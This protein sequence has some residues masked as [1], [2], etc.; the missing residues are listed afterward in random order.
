MNRLLAK[1]VVLC[2]GLAISSILYTA[3]LDL[4]QSPL[5]VSNSVAPMTMIVLT[6]D[7]KLY[8]EAYNDA[9]DVDGDGELDIGFNPNIDYFGYF[10][11]YK[12]YNYSSGD[13]YFY[14]VSVT[15][16][17]QCA[18]NWSGNFLNYVTTARLDALRKVLYGGYRSTDTRDLTILER[19]Y[20]PQD[21]HSWGK[22]YNSV[23][24]NGYNISNYTPFSKPSSNRYHLFANTTLKNDESAGPLLRVALDQPYRI[25]EWVS[26]ERPVA[27][28]RARNGRNGPRIY[29][30]TD[31]AVRVKV[32]DS[33]VGLEANCSVYPNGRYKPTGLLQ[34]F[35][36][37]DSM[38]FGLMTGS[39]TNNIQGGVLRKQIG[40]IQNEINLNNG[41]F[42]KVN[43]II[44][45][46]N[47]LNI[48]NFD[49]D[50]E[51]NP[52]CGFNAGA[53]V[54]GQCA[55]WG[56]P[57]A[58]IMYEAT[59]YFAGKNTPTSNFTY[60]S[61]LDDTLGL[62]KP[63][64]NNPY[65]DFPVCSKANLLVI[66]DIYPDYDSD[67]I[68][69]SYFQSTS[70]DLA[71]FNAQAL[72]QTIFS[73]EGLS[74]LQVFIGQSGADD[75]AAPTPK[76]VT[77]FG[78]IRGL[79]PHEPSSEGSYYAA[80]VSYFGLI[81]DV[82]GAEGKQN[83]RTYIVGLS[84]NLPEFKFRVGDRTIQ[85]IPYAKTVGHRD[86]TVYSYKPT[87]AI[88]DYYIET[89]TPNYALFRINFEIQQQG[90]DFDMDAIVIYEV[91]V[92]PNNT[93]TV[94]LISDEAAGERIQHLGY[95]I[96]GTTQDGMYLEV[97]DSATISSDDQ[98]YI[99]DTP[100]GKLPGGNGIDGK[101]LPLTASRTFTPSSTSAAVF[102]QS[103]LWY[104]A[105]W[106]GF[107]DE[108]DNNIPDLSTEWDSDGDGNPDNYFLVN[109]S[110]NLNTQLT[111]LFQKIIDE[112]TS[113]ASV[114]VS[115]GFLGSETKIFQ[116]IF[117]PQGW[118]G[119]L[120]A[121]DIDQNNGNVLRN[122]GA[123]LGARW[124][125][126]IVLKN[127]NYDSGRK[128]I[129][130]NYSSGKGVPFRWPGNPANPGNSEI[131]LA[132]VT[133]L[134]TNPSTGVVDNRGADRLNYLRGNQALEQKNGG[135]FRDR[136]LLLGDI[137]NSAPISISVPIEAYPETWANNDA[138][139]D[140]SYSAFRQAKKN[141]IPVVYVGA[142]DGM[143]HA[144]NA[145][146]GA[147][148]L[149]FVPSS[150]YNN[151][152]YLTM[153]S[154]SHRYY[155][156][157]APTVIDALLNN[158][159]RT[160]LVAGLNG[161]GQA[162]YALDITNPEQFSEAAAN[163][164]VLWEFTDA[165]DADLGFTYSQPSIVRMANGKWA[166][167]FGNGYN[168]TAADGRVSSTGNAVIYV[169]DLE[170]KAIIKKFDTGVGMAQD[171]TGLGRPNGM[172][173]PLVIDTS[174]NSVADCIYAGDLFGNLWK[175]DVTGK[176]PNGWG[177]SFK[178]G[179]SPRP[180]FQAR[181]INGNAQAITSQP[182]VSRLSLTQDAYQIYIGTGKY[183]ENS[184]R[185]D[186]SVQTVYA[187]RDQNNVTISGRAD[188]V[189]QSII[190]ESNITRITSDN[191]LANNSR[192]WYMDL[193][194][195][196][197]A[198]GERIISN[199]VYLNGKLIFPTIIPNEDA[200]SSGGESWLMEINALNGGRLNYNVFDLNNDGATDGG[201]SVT[202]SSGG[203]TIDTTA[204]GLKSNVGLI[205][206]PS[207]LNAG[208]KEYKYLS[209]SGSGIQKVNENPGN[210]TTGRQ[211]WK[212]IK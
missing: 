112:T 61:G 194:F 40:S 190:A 52:N 75:D 89:L 116:A 123:T 7:H 19:T 67:N 143:L 208:G 155:V 120:L 81:N 135:I 127:Q 121:Y 134:N 188:L 54:N 136:T 207:I 133:A 149:A 141:R 205:S 111:A 156:D 53:L 42:T 87:N 170:T 199:M 130:Y 50:Y 151:L 128:I 63:N 84:S 101:P 23:A 80:S 15:A 177:F 181:D 150:V 195:N 30:I 211:S 100:P 78:N 88:V 27:G 45:T 5:F 167:V 173:Q 187:L 44:S 109:N 33:A 174:G 10:D 184:D 180:F 48:V 172:A 179:S 201:D 41:R 31:Y 140:V 103:P 66:S 104:A 3:P 169:V 186:L 25:W 146:T 189:Q 119:Q 163:S 200:C 160:V 74:S 165:D 69:G 26:I 55:M 147:E 35:G 185:S 93:L 39:Y 110:A 38:Y 162:V 68:P 107:E 176:N 115:S 72:G 36:E 164:I 70:G 59:R 76:T 183:L 148:I 139:N 96:S 17:K 21:A 64:W 153:P 34:K 204:S 132:G 166:A 58:E 94:N 91:R 8:F 102:L 47:K 122:G 28:A 29:N 126:A 175:I 106:G 210:Q 137:I 49:T 6:R 154:Y 90:G 56:N 83:I 11:S 22:E 171:P 95:I 71:G 118:S 193:I 62:A 65:N 197:N 4:S 113:F 99:H 145:N 191:P 168:N 105:K 157:G 117:N 108:N 206:T 9:T 43:G 142:N 13:R 24:V 37:N 20:I 14:P 18:G 182:A 125:A 16:N 144:F 129:S 124:D 1:L 46:I 57:M 60:G 131:S 77:S 86:G 209:G 196:N 73:G 97:R 32:C 159:W 212:Q 152:P 138:E 158:Q 192:G 198:Q 92:N 161:G 202:Y 79:A 178:Q 51:Y 98:D 2:S 82:N 203:Q 12:C 114:A 85:L